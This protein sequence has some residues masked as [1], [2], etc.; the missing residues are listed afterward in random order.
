MGTKDMVASWCNMRCTGVISDAA[1]VSPRH[2]RRDLLG[3][4]SLDPLERGAAGSP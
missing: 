2:P 1:M 3:H 4:P